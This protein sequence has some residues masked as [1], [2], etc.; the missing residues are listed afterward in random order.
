VCGIWMLVRRPW[1]WRAAHLALT[2]LCVIDLLVCIGGAAII[3]SYKLATGWDGIAFAIGVT[4]V[5]A[6]SALFWLHAVSKLALLP[7][8]VR[9]AFSL[10]DD[11]SA[12]LHAAATLV[13]MILYV[14]TLSVGSLWYVLKQ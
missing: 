11:E 8:K 6:G 5:L 12:R 2:V 1:T 9:R 3:I 13:L 10:G 14:A 4:L 7:T